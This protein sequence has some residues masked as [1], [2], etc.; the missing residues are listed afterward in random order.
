M[1]ASRQVWNASDGKDG[2]PAQPFIT[3]RRIVDR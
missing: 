3:C 1:C 2:W